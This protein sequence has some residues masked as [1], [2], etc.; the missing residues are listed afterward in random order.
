MATGSGF[1]LFAN[2]RQDDMQA[3]TTLATQAMQPGQQYMPQVPGQPP[4][5]SQFDTSM[6]QT[7]PPMQAPPPAA[8][9]APAATPAAAPT[10]LE[11]ETTSALPSFVPPTMYTRSWEND[12]DKIIAGESGGDPNALLGFA[13]RNDFAGYNVSEKTLGELKEFGGPE[14]PYGK[15]S[16]NKL[17]Y[18]ATPMGKFQIVRDTLAAAQ[19]ALGLPDDTVFDEQTQ[20]TM[21][22][23]VYENQGWQAFE[24]LKKGGGGDGAPGSAPAPYQSPQDIDQL[25]AMFGL[26]RDPEKDAAYRRGATF[27]ALSQGLS[28]LSRGQPID[29]SNILQMVQDRQDSMRENMFRIYQERQREEERTEDYSIEEQRRA[30]DAAAAAATAEL[31]RSQTVADAA[32]S[33]EHDYALANLG[34]GY[35]LSELVAENDAKLSLEDTERRR[36]QFVASNLLKQ[37]DPILRRVGEVMQAGDIGFEEAFKEV[38]PNSPLVDLGTKMPVVKYEAGVKRI[39]RE[40]QILD[41]SRS[42]DQALDQMLEIYQANN[43]DI[44]GGPLTAA[45]QPYAGVL[46]QLGLL[47][48]DG[49]RMLSLQEAIQANKFAA[50]GTVKQPGQQSNFE[51]EQYLKALPGIEG[52]PLG[53]RLRL[54]VGTANRAAARQRVDM[55]DEYLAENENLEGFDKWYNQQVDEGNTPDSLLTLDQLVAN[56]TKTSNLIKNGFLKPG[57]LVAMND[58]ATGKSTLVPIDQQFIDSLLGE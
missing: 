39:D 57:T 29:L 30:E 49:S 56:S 6:Y 13:N 2:K 15:Y 54:Q 18:R 38:N 34:H 4:A 19:E 23:W 45:F 27:M 1:L 11:G 51:L 44:P 36:R 8:P 25:E 22:K 26:E 47:S 3:F 35:K 16:K 52:T 12:R 28:Q 20:E 55:M 5:M 10:P 32:A 7:Q 9:A 48:E 40:R 41:E 50:I 31:E 24:A 17:G 46:N 21:A 42:S 43:W 33:R 14:G 37:T 58:P 53:N